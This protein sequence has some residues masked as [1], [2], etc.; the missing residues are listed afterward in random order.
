[1]DILLHGIETIESDAGPRPVETIDTGIIGLVFTAPDADPELWP[2]DRCVAVHGLA[3]F[4]GGLGKGGTGQD[5]F[6]AIF[7]QATR[8]S[9]TVVAVRARRV[10]MLP[11][12]GR[13]CWARRWLGPACTRSGTPRPNWRSNRNS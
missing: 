5:A 12:P 11:L 8:A 1:M 7:D 13:T 10:P 4:P 6:D 3:G 2:L 9:Q